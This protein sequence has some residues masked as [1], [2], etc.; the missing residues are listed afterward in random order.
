MKGYGNVAPAALTVTVALVELNVA[1]IRSAK[2]ERMVVF[3]RMGCFPVVLNL[4]FIFGS[5]SR[6][7]FAYIL[8]AQAKYI[9]NI[10]PYWN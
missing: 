1:K 5:D 8:K 4:K 9:R 10:S 6:L 3:L 2:V 7:R